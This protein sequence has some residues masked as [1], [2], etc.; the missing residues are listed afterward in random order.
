MESEV[1]VLFRLVDFYKED[2]IVDRLME[3]YESCTPM[4]RLTDEEVIFNLEHV[5]TVDFV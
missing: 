4:F 5:E 3:N 1:K 2:T